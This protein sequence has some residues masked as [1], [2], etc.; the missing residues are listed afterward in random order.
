M[1]I[2]S[3]FTLSEGLEVECLVWCPR[4]IVEERDRSAFVRSL[5]WAR[6]ATRGVVGDII[7]EILNGVDIPCVSKLA[8]PAAR[9]TYRHWV[10]ETDTSL[11]LPKAEDTDPSTVK[12]LWV[13]FEIVSRILDTSE[14]SADEV[15]KVIS[16]IKSRFTMDTN[17]S[18]GLH[19]HI[20]NGLNGFPLA[21][22][23]KFS[24][25]V[26][27]FEHLIHTLHPRERLDSSWCKP[28]SRCAEFDDEPNLNLRLM[29]IERTGCV[30]DLIVEVMNPNRERGCAYNLC[31]LLLM[32]VPGEQKLTIEF[33]QHAG[34]VDQQTIVNW[35]GFAAALVEFSHKVPESQLLFLCTY[36]PQD[37]DFSIFSLMETIGRG[38]LVD[39]YRDR[40]FVHDTPEARS[41]SGNF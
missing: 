23:K 25:L 41:D 35:M 19:V 32:G 14:E 27:A 12:G 26:V 22:L 15:K 36:K 24:M 1:S 4:R 16:L 5:P 34:S 17:R 20:G 9:T 21:T 38:N 8:R 40:T 31:N 7:S 11:K 33:R 39:F 28:P 13:A 30:D 29:K 10:L 37:P 2:M 18:T 3:N 6:E